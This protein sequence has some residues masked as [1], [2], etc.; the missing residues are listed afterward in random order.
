[1]DRP[2]WTDESRESG[3]CASCGPGLS[4]RIL[5]EESLTPKV[6]SF[7]VRYRVVPASYELCDILLLK[8]AKIKTTGTLPSPRLLSYHARHEPKGDSAH[9]PHPTHDAQQCLS[10]TVAHR[11]GRTQY[12]VNVMSR[13]GSIAVTARVLGVGHGLAH[14]VVHEVDPLLVLVDQAGDTLDAVTASQTADVVAE[15]FAVTLGAA[16][17]QS[18]ATLSTSRHRELPSLF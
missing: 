2:P 13:D 6:K 5:T 18:L 9:A 10:Y 17:A 4:Q 11:Q 15:Y 7:A 8:H 12:G 1:M 3:E 14:Q 16:L